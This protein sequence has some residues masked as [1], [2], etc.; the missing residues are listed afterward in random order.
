MTSQLS[1]DYC[2]ILWEPESGNPVTPTKYQIHSFPNKPHF[3]AQQGAMSIYFA[4]TYGAEHMPTCSAVTA[5]TGLPG[6]PTLVLR[7][8]H[9]PHRGSGRHPG[10]GA[11]RGVDQRPLP[12]RFQVCGC[13]HGWASCLICTALRM[14]WDSSS[15]DAGAL[16]LATWAYEVWS[17]NSISVGQNV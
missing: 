16:K 10:Q 3:R 13:A 14:A 7:L 11:G 12:K 15:C 6:V 8:P 9:V 5:G 2:Q 17:L 4:L 1:T